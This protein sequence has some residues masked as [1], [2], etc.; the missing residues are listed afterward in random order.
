MSVVARAQFLQDDLRE[1]DAEQPA[2]PGIQME[3]VEIALGS[4][5]TLK[6]AFGQQDRLVTAAKI[7][8]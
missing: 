2:A 4:L 7:P 3:G 6:R 1:H 8:D 5:E